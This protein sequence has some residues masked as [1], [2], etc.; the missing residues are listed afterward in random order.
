MSVLAEPKANASTGQ[1]SPAPAMLDCLLLLAAPE[2]YAAALGKPEAMQLSASIVR[3][4]A[5]HGLFTM[6]RQLLSDVVASG[7]ASSTPAGRPSMAAALVQ[8]LSVRALMLKGWVPNSPTDAPHALLFVPGLWARCGPAMQLAAPRLLQ[9]SLVHLAPW[10]CAGHLVELLPQDASGGMAGA[11]TALLGNLLT[12][13]HKLLVVPAATAAAQQSSIAG[14]A[15]AAAQAPAAGQVREAALRLTKVLC[16]AVE[17]L[18]LQPFFGAAANRSDDGSAE[19]DS[20]SGT[21][22]LT[23]PTCYTPLPE[24]QSVV[25]LLTS[26]TGMPL[27]RHLVPVLLPHTRDSPLS[28]DPQWGHESLTALQGAC[29]SAYSLC[30]LVEALAVLPQQH[31][32]VML[33]LVIS[34]DIVER[35][36][37]SFLRAARAAQLADVEL[38]P[39]ELTGPAAVLASS[40]SGSFASASRPSIPALGSGSANYSRGGAAGEDASKSSLAIGRASGYDSGTMGGSSPI[41][42]SSPSSGSYMASYMDIDRPSSSRAAKSAADASTASTSVPLAG[43]SLSSPM[44]V[45]IAATPSLLLTGS[46]PGSRLGPGIT[47]LSPKD[48]ARLAALAARVRSEKWS[49]LEDDPGW[50]LPLLVLCE[51]FSAHIMTSSLD[52]FDVQQRPIALEQLYSAKAPSMGLLATLRDALW[53]VLWIDAERPTRG[54]AAMTAGRSTSASCNAALTS[55]TSC[56]DVLRAALAESCGELYAQLCERNARKAFCPSDVFHAPSLAAAPER[57]YIEATASGVLPN[58]REGAG[59]D[60]GG[61]HAIADGWAASAGQGAGAG[62]GQED[63]GRVW[64][65]LRYAPVLVPFEERARL[66]QGMVA[67]EREVGC[68]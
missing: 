54:A 52:E 11:V 42:G 10:A 58:M 37:W 36:W 50:M 20:L 62:A 1:A 14:Q 51:A 56:S 30:A 38:F 32:P 44:A 43:T 8:Q 29:E 18:P 2:T 27:L 13:G 5:G 17:L 49:P 57:F 33:T 60:G 24:M 12:E 45:R 23:F 40:S 48:H 53:Q 41:F 19:T 67:E 26:L 31:Q 9:A 35:L 63:G 55:A 64:R 21:Q 6:L 47:S 7:P 15:A 66:F 4:L 65:V 68:A 61:D 59:T 28:W 22:R 39:P 16:A 25:Q 46:S 3:H 34:A